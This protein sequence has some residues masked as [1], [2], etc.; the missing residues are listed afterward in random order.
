MTHKKCDELIGIKFQIKYWN[1][2][3]QKKWKYKK[4]THK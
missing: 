2:M 3:E 4:I 1:E